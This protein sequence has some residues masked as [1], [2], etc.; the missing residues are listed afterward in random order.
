MFAPDGNRS[1]DRVSSADDRQHRGRAGGDVAL[2]PEHAAEASAPPALD[3]PE[4]CGPR[5]RAAAT[6]VAR[7]SSAEDTSDRGRRD[8]WSRRRTPRRPL[9]W[10][11]HVDASASLVTTR[12]DAEAGRTRSRSCDSAAPGR[13]RRR[14]VARRPRQR[15]AAPASVSARRCG[16]LAVEANAVTPDKRPSPR[17]RRARPV[18]MRVPPSLD[19]LKRER[20]TRQR[21]SYAR[22]RESDRHRAHA[23]SSSPE[24][25][26]RA[27]TARPP[28]HSSAS[29]AADAMSTAARRDRSYS[30]A[31]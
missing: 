13:C 9:A 16:Q 20:V 8:A 14:P 29:R 12:G 2:V 24:G 31:R 1:H 5:C 28:R 3:A 27:G 10:P 7:R 6:P 15:D 4:A 23:G 19:A 21:R 26:R 30:V 18:S 11:Q 17:R 25:P 22:C